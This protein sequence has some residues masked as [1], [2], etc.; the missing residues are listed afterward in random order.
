MR[1][2]V[3]VLDFGSQ[4]TQLIARRIRELG[5]FSEIRPFH[6]SIDEIIEI[7]PK[8]MI[9]SGGPASVWD[10]CSPSL[11]HKILELGIPILGICYGMQLIVHLLGGKVERSQRREFGPSEVEIT[12]Y[13]DIFSGIPQKTSVW[14]SHSDRV[15]ELPAGFSAIASSVNSP[16]AA[17]KSDRDK[18][19][20]IQFHA[21]VVHTGY[22][23]EILSNFIFKIAGC[24]GDWTPKSFADDTI[25]EIREKVGDSNV[26]CAI[27]GGVDSSVTALILQRAV[28]DRLYCFFVDTGLLR[29]DEGSEVLDV[30]RK[31]G[32]NVIHVDATD[33]FLRK[34]RGVEDPEEKRK[35]IGEEFIRVFEEEASKINKAEFLAQGTLYPDVIESVSVKGP[36][37]KIKSHHNV[38]GLPE[39]MKLELVEPLRELFKDEV[40]EVGRELGLRPDILSRHPFPGPGLAI[41]II[42]EVDEDKIRD[43]RQSDAI[44]IEE[45]KKAGIYDDIWQAFCVFLPIKTVGVMGDERTYEN[46]IALRAV[47][48]VDGMTADWA[49]IP[50]DVLETVSVRIINEVK[51]VNRVVYDVSTKPPSTIEWE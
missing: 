49:R 8:A 31:M 38:G 18:I 14:M 35:I 32:L 25:K 28:W 2:K 47:T 36:S 48:S 17:I 29:L 50:Y 22:G 26:V 3:L 39:K 13:A 33:R 40:R 12:D 16:I 45:L 27:S 34:L 7:Q 11:T 42:G 19:F 46:V 30:Y 15:L 37:S 24:D 10:D 9:L 4:Y 6:I 23:K 5:V 51:G 20:G 41:R 44:F 43:L 21:E 1:E